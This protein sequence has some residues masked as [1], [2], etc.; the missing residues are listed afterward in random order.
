M[1][2]IN[3]QSVLNTVAAVS[4]DSVEHT[5]ATVTPKPRWLEI[6]GPLSPSNGFTI[7]ANVTKAAR[8]LIDAIAKANARLETVIEQIAQIENAGLA[9]RI[10]GDNPNYR[11]F[12]PDGVEAQEAKD[13]LT[14]EQQVLTNR[15]MEGQRMLIELIEWAE[16]NNTAL[17]LEVEVGHRT[18][19]D[20]IGNES[21]IPRMAP[22]DR[23]TLVLAIDRQRQFIREQRASN[24]R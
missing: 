4:N 1:S 20:I 8:Q 9:G 11:G 21:R 18:V 3:I 19:T 22:L 12:N 13:A 17:N 10:P 14:E 5:P 16:A 23:D 6:K 15:V 7:A 24:L 2:A